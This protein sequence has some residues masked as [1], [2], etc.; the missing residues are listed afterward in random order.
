MN[1]VAFWTDTTKWW[2]RQS[3]SPM[4]LLSVV[5]NV[6]LL[7]EPE[8]HLTPNN[9]QQPVWNQLLGKW[10]ANGVR[11]MNANWL[12]SG[13]KW[14]MQSEWR[15]VDLESN[16]DVGQTLAEKRGKEWQM[17]SPPLEFIR[18]ANHFRNWINF[19]TTTHRTHSC[20]LCFLMQ[21]PNRLV[22]LVKASTLLAGS[23]SQWL[24]QLVPVSCRDIVAGDRWDL[25]VIESVVAL[26]NNGHH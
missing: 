2:G 22:C 25:G 12:M 26:E 23:L 20:L 13:R 17:R 14:R 1:A 5:A 19:W 21:E 9:P 6:Y 15:D 4:R 16:S 24:F 3:V 7:A 11:W 10:P 8:G 18:L